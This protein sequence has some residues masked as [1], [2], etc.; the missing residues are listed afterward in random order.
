MEGSF[1]MSKGEK[2]QFKFYRRRVGP[3]SSS[4]GSSRST[5]SLPVDDELA[6]AIALAKGPSDTLLAHVEMKIKEFQQAPKQLTQFAKCPNYNC[7][8]G[9]KTRDHHQVNSMTVAVKPCPICVSK[10]SSNGNAN[11]SAGG[12][13]GATVGTT[14]GASSSSSGRNVPPQPSRDDGIFVLGKTHSYMSNRIDLVG[15]NVGNGMISDEVVRA[16]DA[17]G[18][19]AC[20]TVCFGF[21][22]TCFTKRLLPLDHPVPL[23]PAMISNNHIAGEVDAISDR[24]EVILAY[25]R[26]PQ[27]IKVALLN[28]SGELNTRQ[29]AWS[30]FSKAKNMANL[31]FNHQFGP[32]LKEACNKALIKLGNL[33]IFSGSNAELEDL[34]SQI[35][36]ASLELEKLKK[37]GA[38]KD[39]KITK[40]ESE[41]VANRNSYDALK[42]KFDEKV[43][44]LKE[45]KK[46]NEPPPAPKNK[47]KGK[48]ATTASE[49]DNQNEP[50][51]KQSGYVM[52][53]DLVAAVHSA[54]AAYA[55]SSTS[56]T[57]LPL[58]TAAAAEVDPRASKRHKT[59][60]SE[61]PPNHA[62]LPASQEPAATTS[63]L[64]PTTGY[65][66]EVPTEGSASV[67]HQMQ[68]IPHPVPNQMQHIPHAVPMMPQRQ[69]MQQLGMRLHPTVVS[70]H[71]QSGGFATHIHGQSQADQALA[72][73]NVAYAVQPQQVLRPS[74][75]VQPQQVLRPSP[76]AYAY[77]YPQE[78]AYYQ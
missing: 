38:V 9:Y 51:S 71:M 27:G 10:A 76:S 58:P 64:E 46:K 57:T 3:P 36:E 56:A 12:A 66:Y 40:L 6:K 44:E 61:T 19:K 67:L 24:A 72:L 30:S 70:H 25:V 33:K 69:P 22:R 11:A 26:Q 45:E 52:K 29:Q 17:A 4:S 2:K 13:A 53:G 59:T 32:T 23:C 65:V 49:N 68:H 60:H 41:A 43:K 50:S 42:G 7:S 48:S 5:S 77:P 54:L 75:A 28:Q 1:G 8:N 14:P 63:Y 47:G 18:K 62:H 37:E 31:H 55:S 39:T 74:P 73:R 34:R 20:D 78:F 21:N 15:L 16:L 35:H